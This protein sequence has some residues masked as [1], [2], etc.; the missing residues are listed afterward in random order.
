M[1]V[2]GTTPYPWPYDGPIDAGRTALLCIDWQTDF[3]GPG[4]YVDTMGYDLDLTRSV[5]VIEWGRGMA[6]ELSDA[7]AALRLSVR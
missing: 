6:E 2:I 5:V 7:V 4:G 3:C 1:H